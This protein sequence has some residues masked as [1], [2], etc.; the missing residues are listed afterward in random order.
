MPLFSAERIKKNVFFVFI[1]K[2]LIL[3]KYIDKGQEVKNDLDRQDHIIKK[4]EKS[5]QEYYFLF[6]KWNW[7]AEFK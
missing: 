5:F 2:Y 3:L 6:R 4:A 7:Q 1:G